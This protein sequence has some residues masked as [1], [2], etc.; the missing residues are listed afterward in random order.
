MHALLNLAL[1]AA[2][3]AAELLAHQFDR[4]DRVKKL[5]AS[6]HG[7]LTSANLD[8]EKSIL[9]HLQKAHPEHCYSSR[10][11]DKIEGSDPS[12]VW[13]IDPMTG[14]DN[15][16]KGVPHFAVSVACQIDNQIQH[17]VL[18]NPLL[19]EEF[20]ASR[21]QGANLGGRRLRVSAKSRLQGSLVAL[22]SPAEEYLAESLELQQKLVNSGAAIS[23]SG[24]ATLDLANTAAGRFVG[25]ITSNIDSN[26]LASALLILQESGGLIG[27]RQGNPDVSNARTLVF[28]NPGC[29]KQILK[30]QP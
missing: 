15:F 8:A 1:R 10:G 3:D 6:T 27:D 26:S 24:C 9:Y 4:L 25:G 7:L 2:R 17:A 21:G 19:N 11:S 29:F 16:V 20:S 14:T 12:V 30:L 18:I 28:G 22:D 13:L 23:M 5:E